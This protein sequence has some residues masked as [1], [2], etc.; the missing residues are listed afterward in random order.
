MIQSCT[1]SHI[2]QDHIL[3]KIT[4]A[5]RTVHPTAK[6]AHRRL[7]RDGASAMNLKGAKTI[8]ERAKQD[9]N[10]I[11]SELANV[12][13]TVTFQLGGKLPKFRESVPVPYRIRKTE[14]GFIFRARKR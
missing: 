4:G 2:R 6:S 3:S 1:E 7:A 12:A 8:V 5:R 9:H 11:D 13:S 14:N 10:R